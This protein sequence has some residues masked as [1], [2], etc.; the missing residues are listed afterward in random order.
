MYSILSGR[1]VPKTP[2]PAADDRRHVAPARRTR[3]DRRGQAHPRGPSPQLTA[4]NW[5]DMTYAHR[6]GHV[7]VQPE[8]GAGHSPC[9]DPAK[10][11]GRL[12]PAADTRPDC[13]DS[14]T[15]RIGHVSESR[16]RTSLCT[17]VTACPTGVPPLFAVG[18]RMRV[19]FRA[20]ARKPDGRFANEVGLVRRRRSAGCGERG[21]AGLQFEAAWHAH[22][23]GRPRTGR[24]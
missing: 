24:R 8:R 2:V 18:A 15:P 12:L 19:T 22:F 3:R 14:Q 10:R 20:A 11:T 7:G 13:R 9:S 1:K 21:I 4:S 23:E 6:R 5:R 16:V 17:S